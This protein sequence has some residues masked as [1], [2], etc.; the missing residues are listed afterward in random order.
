M[1]VCFETVIVNAQLVE[2]ILCDWFST[3][4]NVELRLMQ[5]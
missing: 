4:L 1:N 2:E 5:R 3:Y